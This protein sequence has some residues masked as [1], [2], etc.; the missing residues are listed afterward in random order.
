M[1]PVTGHQV[2]VT[3]PAFLAPDITEAILVGCQPRELTAETLTR[4]ESLPLSWDE[5]RDLLGFARS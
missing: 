4:M 3:R 1:Q 5:Q 2:S